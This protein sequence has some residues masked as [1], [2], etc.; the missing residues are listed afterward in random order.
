M[1]IKTLHTILRVD[2]YHLDDLSIRKAK[3][4]KKAAF[5]HSELATMWMYHKLFI[6]SRRVI[7]HLREFCKNQVICIC[8]IMILLINLTCDP[9]VRDMYVILDT[10]Y[11]LIEENIIPWKRMDNYQAVRKS[12]RYEPNFTM[13]M[14]CF[15]NKP[16]Y[17]PTLIFSVLVRV[18][19][20]CR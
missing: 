5:N 19:S 2:S 9:W 18:I 15:R 16:R 7:P 14:S 3:S 13:V 20:C 8:M 11:Y 12:N 10:V 17:Q 4:L 1:K 6:V